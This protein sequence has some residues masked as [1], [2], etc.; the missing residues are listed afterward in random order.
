MAF[1]NFARPQLLSFRVK[2]IVNSL[3]YFNA[4]NQRSLSC[5]SINKYKE[6]RQTETDKSI[7]IEGVHV[8][9]PRKEHLIKFEDQK[10]VKCTTCSLCRF[11]IPIKHTDVLIL[12]Q[13]VTSYG[14]VIPKKITNICQEQHKRIE[15]LVIMAQKAGLMPMYKDKVIQELSGWEAYNKYYDEAVIDEFL[16]GRRNKT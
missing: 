1:T 7:T 10:G 12:N 5:T 15:Y 2:T 8:E 4:T 3:S 16:I 14:K 13:F 9:S 6:I 11:G